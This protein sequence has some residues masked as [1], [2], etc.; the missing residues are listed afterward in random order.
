MVIPGVIGAM[1]G[2]Y[3]LTSIH[4]DIVKPFVSI[5]LLVMGTVIIRKATRKVIEKKKV[6]RVGL[7]ALFGGFLDSIGGGGWGPVVTSTLL[8]KG[9][10]PQYTIG[11]VNATVIFS[12]FPG[13]L[14][15]DLELYLRAING[16]I[17]MCTTNLPASP[18]TEGRV[19]D[20]GVTIKRTLGDMGFDLSKTNIQ[21]TNSGLTEVVLR[22]GTKSA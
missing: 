18:C 19:L 20:P 2:A 10:N 5:Y 6:Q 21:F 7:L 3:I 1:A 22:A 9:R 14:P 4:G 12:P 16:S 8:S 13:P 15:A 17:V 11:T